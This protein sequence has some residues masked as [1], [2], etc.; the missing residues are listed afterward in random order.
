MYEEFGF[1]PG[2][3]AAP[4]AQQN[5]QPQQQT[6][7]YGNNGGHSHGGGYNRGGY[8]G[9]DGGFRR[10]PPKEVVTDQAYAPI[11]VFVDR[12]FPQE[13]KDRL[14]GV[15][16]KLVS[17]QFTVRVNGDDKDFIAS[18]KDISETNLE[19]YIPWKPFNDI[20]TKHY[21]N[22]ESS[23]L[24][25]AKFFPAW[26]KIP[27]SAK[28]FLARNMRLLFGDKNNSCVKALVTW[29]EDG[30]SRTSEISQST[31]K[32][33]QIIRAATYY[34]TPVFNVQKAGTEDALAK[35]FNFV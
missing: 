16:I 15:I 31:G 9:N 13:V 1:D 20:E 23:K 11:G 3:S 34:S 24:I 18:L 14:R 33:S 12:A 30:A 2:E 17:K 8:G 32:S 27:D 6:K 25:A 5:H 26:D 21:F 10:Q 29:S 4:P 7:S 28:A 22:T 35:V 19:I